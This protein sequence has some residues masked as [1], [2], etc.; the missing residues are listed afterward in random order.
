MDALDHRS[1]LR[2]RLNAACN[3]SQRMTTLTRG[4]ALTISS[5]HEELL[6]RGWSDKD[7]AIA[8]S[9]ALQFIERELLDAL[10]E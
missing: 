9:D 1:L 5:L 8:I 7:S 4:L 3:E 6:L 10:V 2:H